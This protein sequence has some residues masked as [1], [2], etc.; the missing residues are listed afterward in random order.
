MAGYRADLDAIHAAGRVLTGTVDAVAAALDG[1]D[2]G[3]CAVLGPGRLGP[4]AA[5]LTEHTRQDLDRVL[6]AITDN[7]GLVRSAAAAYAE[8]DRAAAD[9]LNRRAGGPD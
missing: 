6:A 8:Q 5:A 3:L 7:A 1:L 9:A 2:G 4:A